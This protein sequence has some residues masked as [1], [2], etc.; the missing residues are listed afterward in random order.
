MFL[1]IRGSTLIQFVFETK[2]L[3]P[4]RQNENS[5]ELDQQNN[6]HDYGGEYIRFNYFSATDFFVCEQAYQFEAAVLVI[7]MPQ[8]ERQTRY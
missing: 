1:R 8:I 6:N 3:K 5:P 7:F 4:F 2:P